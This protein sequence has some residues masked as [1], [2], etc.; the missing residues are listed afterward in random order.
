MRVL[1][2][3]EDSRARDLVGGTVRAVGGEVLSSTSVPEAR[4]HLEKEKLHVVV[5]DC[6]LPRE[7]VGPFGEEIRD[8]VDPIEVIVLEDLHSLDGVPDWAADF[9]TKPLSEQKLR[10][11]LGLVKRRVEQADTVGE[12][13]LAT[14]VDASADIIEITNPNAILLY[15][16]PAFERTLGY[17]AEE[18]VGKTPA[19][20]IRSEMHSREFFEEL[21][22]TLRAGRTWN[23]MLISQSKDGRQI[24]LESTISPV[25]D[26]T[27]KVTHHV[28]VKRDVTSRVE[29]EQELKVKH[30]EL[31][32][33]RDQALAANRAKSQFLANISHELRTPLN[34]IIGYSEMLSE[35]AQDDGQTELVDDLGKITKAGRHLLELINDV[36][37]ISKIEAGRMEVFVEDFKVADLVMD[38]ISTVKPMFLSSENQLVVDTS[39]ELGDMR[40]DQTKV[41]QSLLNLLSNANKFTEKGEVR[42]RVERVERDG[43]DWV[44]FS[45]ED[46]GI[47]LSQEQQDKI[48]EPFQQADASMTRKYGGTGLGLAI[49]QRVCGM[50]G[51]Y[52]E[53]ESEVGKGSTFTVHVPAC[54][55]VSTSRPT[56]PPAEAGE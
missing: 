9:V 16:N 15:V 27:G 24:Y 10:A 56:F 18:A 54:C 21:D 6:A 17:T 23:G 35:D 52:I 43:H 55:D 28:G 8:A 3:T 19:M 30:R 31:T 32:E 38:V 1:V 39:A 4:D 2:V 25:K 20:L 5:I 29:A 11:R 14:A 47:G 50:I 46:T 26:E 48:F 40:S 42:F 12:V 49:S 34:A 7:D 41:R 13:P 53:I 36:L 22:D 37:D 51:G 44:C 45:V 33:A